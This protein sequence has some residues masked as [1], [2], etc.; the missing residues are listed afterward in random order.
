VRVAIASF[1]PA[2]E[3]LLV[4]RGNALG[5]V[6]T[7]IRDDTLAGGKGVNVARVFAQLSTPQFEPTGLASAVE[8]LPRLFGP[9]GGA[10]GDLLLALMRAE[11]IEGDWVDVAAPTRTNEVIVDEADG[12]NATVYNAIG[13]TI[14]DD[15]IARL[16][17]V[18]FE[19]LVG[20]SALVCTGSIP[21]GMPKDIYAE[22]IAA[23]SAVGIPSILDAHGEILEIAANAAPTIIKVNR[24]ELEE[25]AG[26]AG[27]AS[28]MEAWTR[29]GTMAVIITDG[30]RPV[31][32]I[33]PDGIMKVTPPPTHTISAVGSGDA[34][35]AGLLWSFLRRAPDW[36]G[37]LRLAS[38]CGA[39]NAS[40]AR[41][42][43]SDLAKPAEVEGLVAIRRQTSAG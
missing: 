32:A 11:G 2:I 39:S 6:H 19:A 42:K 22:L 9:L 26:R 16:K 5:K 33:T 25:L 29:A 24:N 43:L 31:A 30:S 15:E 21:P 35:T 4:V 37:H 34:F 36:E 18:A 27:A 3:R 38:A 14:D 10:T 41:A 23:A 7:L 17:A 12:E 8:Q 20:A 13:P 1:N 28:Q 40:G